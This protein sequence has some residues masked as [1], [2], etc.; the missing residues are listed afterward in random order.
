MA[1]NREASKILYDNELREV[2]QIPVHLLSIKRISPY[3]RMQLN[4]VPATRWC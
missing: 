4:K 3:K 1:H 2:V